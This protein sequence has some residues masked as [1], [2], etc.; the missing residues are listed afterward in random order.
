MGRAAPG[1]SLADWLSWLETLSPAAIDLGLERVVEVLQRLQL[2]RPERVVHVAGTNGK[3]SSVAMLE[4][5]YLQQN[6][7]VGCYTSPHI[8]SYNERIRVGG[9]AVSDEQILHAFKRVEAER[10]DVRLTYFEYGTLAAL[11]V[12]ERMAVTT[13]LLEIGLGGRLD[14]VNALE[15]D[16]G[17]I[18]NIARDHVAWLG[19]DIESIGREKA[20]IL[21]P[22]KAFVFA[23]EDIPHSVMRVAEELG[24]D[25]RV[26]GRDY[27]YSNSAHGRWHFSGRDTSLHDLQQPALRGE[28]QLRNA[29][30]VL[31]LVEALG[32]THLLTLD[33]INSAFSSLRLP[34]RL[35]LIERRRRW[36]LDVA[37]NAAAA[38]ELAQSLSAVASAKEVTCIIGVLDDKGI[39]DIVEPLLSQVDEWIAVTV[40][41]PRAIPAAEIARVIAN[42]SGKP[43]IIG[44][45]VMSACESVDAARA[46][47]RPVLVTG[48]FFAVGPA[49][50]WLGDG[51]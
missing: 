13:V 33:T 23:A 37:H 31:A 9:E 18:T 12:F 15:P 21:R 51:P 5:L 46:G 39:A 7:A 44:D 25:L 49:L 11:C 41:S 30:G 29:A 26:L 38:L 1:T 34:G 4:A 20:G 10:Q 48:S 2:S 8:L 17:I 47:E 22:H 50:E 3:G 42:L 36:I 43:C 27:Q 32:D 19:D 14:A 35:Q 28:F 45:S 40:D 16:A 6:P 24:T